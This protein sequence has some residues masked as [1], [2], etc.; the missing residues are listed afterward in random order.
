MGG[1]VTIREATLA[2]VPQ[3]VEMG[4]AFRLSTSYASSVAEN[5]EQM[6]ETATSLIDSLGVVFVAE[7]YGGELVGMIGLVKAVHFISGALTVSEA[8][9]WSD[10]PGIGLRL[11][12]RALAWSR[13][14]G[15]TKLAMIQP[16]D[17]TRVGDLY[18]RLGARCIE[19]CWEF[20]LTQREAVA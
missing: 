9:W 18:E 2:D 20:D 7:N 11:L 5:V 19:A 4:R 8:F 3:L 6:T 13:E 10:M 16:I 12:Y 15:A 1:E 14:Q 17:N